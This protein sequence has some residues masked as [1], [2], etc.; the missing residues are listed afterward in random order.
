MLVDFGAARTVSTATELEHTGTIIGSAGYAAPEQALGKAV[1]ASDLY[2]LGL[3]GMHLLTGEHP[4][5]L[6]SVAAD[7]WVW[8]TYASSPISDALARVLDRLAARSLRSRYASANAALADLLPAGLRPTKATSTALITIVDSP[9]QCCQLWSTPRRIVNGLGVSPNGRAIA[10]ANSDNTVQLWDR[11][12]GDTLHT[13]AQ[14]LGFGQGHTDA[15]TAVQFFP[16]GDQLLSA[17]HDSSIKQWDLG[18]YQLCQTLLH[19]GWKITAIAL[20]PHGNLLASADIEG[21]LSLWDMAAGERKFDL[22]RHAGAVNDVVISPDGTRL[23]SVGEAGTL[24]LWSLPEGHL[25]HTWTHTAGLRAVVLSPVEPV[26]VT[27]DSR[28]R[29]IIWS[30][31]DF[32]NSSLLTT[33]QDAVSAIALSPNG[34]FLATGSRDRNIHIWDWTTTP[35]RQLATLSHDWSV[36]D[37]V[38]TPD[39]RT[40]VSS[41]ADETIR[42]WQ[43]A[44]VSEGV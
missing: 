12:S 38:F 35:K 19:P 39:S 25:I 41:G 43:A 40:L 31:T 2:S 32:D 44:S 14:R 18:Q 33:H 30:L 36:R 20:S 5:D 1:P 34:Q 28:G 21:R 11:Q 23:I 9:W 3:T 22:R 7:R 16:N 13:F 8:R 24:R 29:V 42:F 10:T 37:L 17:S 4:F 15:A 27:G 6:Y 26:I